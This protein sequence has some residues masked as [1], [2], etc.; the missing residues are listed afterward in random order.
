M[1]HVE[2]AP[3]KLQIT[4][5]LGDE[6]LALHG[7]FHLP[8]THIQAVSTDSVPEAL[9]RGF[10]IGTNLPGVK[11]AG[12]FITG[13]GTIFYDFH[14]PDRCLTLSLSHDTYQQVVIEVDR[15][16]DPSTLAAAI[17]GRIGK[18]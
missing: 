14:D 8:Y 13:E 2:V 10:K 9:F 16:Q 17:R 12:T 3:E 6:I 5:S 15:D 1:A 4:L 11:T 7:A 18:A